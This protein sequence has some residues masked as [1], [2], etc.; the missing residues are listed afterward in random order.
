[1]SVAER[2]LGLIGGHPALEVVW[3]KAGCRGRCPDQLKVVEHPTG[4][5][6]DPETPKEL[7]LVL[8]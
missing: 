6:V 5:V 1:M 7:T 3:V 2:V 8:G 4:E